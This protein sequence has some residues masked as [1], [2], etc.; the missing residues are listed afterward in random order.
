LRVSQDIIIQHLIDTVIPREVKS[1]KWKYF[2]ILLPDRISELFTKSYW[3]VLY[4]F[5]QNYLLFT[6][7]QNM[8]N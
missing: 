8:R 6:T 5:A 1:R 2:I 7:I 4:H 3:I